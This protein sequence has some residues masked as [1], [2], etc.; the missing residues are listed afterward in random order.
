[1]LTTNSPLIGWTD[2]V[3]P[4]ETLMDLTLPTTTIDP[5]NRMIVKIY[6]NNDDSSSHNIKWYTEGT[7]YYSFVLTST[8]AIAGT[9]GSSGTS[10]TSGS[11]GTSGTSGSSGT[12][13][14]GFSAITNSVDNR[15]LTSDGTVTSANAEAN[16]TFDGTTL[17]VTGNI[18]GNT[19]NTINVNALVQASLLFLSNN[20]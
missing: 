13:G 18:K 16:I 15:V 1:V 17:E 14:T 11:S 7:S 10:G 5:T 19:S 2:N 3:T 20:T 12:S 4:V 6:C 9:S 8:G